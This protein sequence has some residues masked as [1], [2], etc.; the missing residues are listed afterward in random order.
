MRP[1]QIKLV[2]S[3]SMCN[4]VMID[5][6][7][8]KPKKFYLYGIFFVIL[9]IILV[10]TQIYLIQNFSAWKCFT[11]PLLVGSISSMSGGI[12]R[13]VL[14]WLPG[15]MF[16]AF[17]LFFAV[18]LIATAA[19]VYFFSKR[20][21]FL[22]EGTKS[23][24]EYKTRVY[25]VQRFIGTLRNAIIFLILLSI[26][27]TPSP[28]PTIAADPNALYFLLLSSLAFWFFLRG[29]F[30][31]LSM[32]VS[33]KNVYLNYEV[34]QDYFREINKTAK[35]TFSNNYLMSRAHL[36]T[37][38][39]ILFPIEFLLVRS[40]SFIRALNKR[41][42]ELLREIKTLLFITTVADGKKIILKF[43]ELEGSMK[44]YDL[45]FLQKVYDVDG[46]IG[47]IR[48]RYPDYEQFV[49]DTYVKGKFEHMKEI[50]SNN[51]KDFILTY[52]PTF[53]TVFGSI[54]TIISFLL[55][56]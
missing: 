46:Q 30:H 1:D 36:G 12:I 13:D 29:L 16:L 5:G 44:E 3:L 21:A 11:S 53:A 43:S 38:V 41:I 56:R 39:E 26:L 47:I 6:F 24:V 52:V 17:L 27:I 7:D 42:K 37:R 54:V 34:V 22:F 8:K 20:I 48:R 50:Y 40:E 4:I 49:N 33:F 15:I 19:F 55:L 9:L 25:D 18:Y 51:K 31:P 2:F 14:L 10:L 32:W 23:I 45:D 35:A 28:C